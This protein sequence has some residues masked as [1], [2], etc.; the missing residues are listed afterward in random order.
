M[1]RLAALFLIMIM[2]ALTVNVWA[3]SLDLSAYDDTALVELLEQV[4]Q[5]V[6]DRHIEK[7]A[8]LQ[9]GKYIGGRDVP[10]GTYI[11]T[12]MATGEDW[13]NVTVYTLDEN[14]NHD[15][16][17]VWQVV[18][19]PE[20]GEEQESFLITLNEGDELSSQVPFSLTIYTGPAF[21]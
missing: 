18:S 20:N 16:Q 15:K 5:E 7:T 21:K 12:C 10:S 19:A 2:T 3:D 4:Q 11:W 13:G 17:S 1:K 9:S 6:T 8:E 14:G